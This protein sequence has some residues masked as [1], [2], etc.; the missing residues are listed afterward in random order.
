M[1]FGLVRAAGRQLCVNG[2]REDKP[3]SPIV[4]DGNTTRDS[5]Q[6]TKSRLGTRWFWIRSDNWLATVMLCGADDGG[7]PPTYVT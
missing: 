1:N 4:A 7:K 2:S 3:F 5:N 6:T